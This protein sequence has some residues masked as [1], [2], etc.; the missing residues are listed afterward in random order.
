VASIAPSRRFDPIVDARV[1]ADLSER[2]RVVVLGDIGGFGIGSA[3]DFTWH[4]LAALG[5]R[6]SESW[7]LSAGYRALESE[8]PAG[9]LLYHGPILGLGHRF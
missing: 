8:R 6:P 1:R 3:S 4:V 5:L 9:D 7:M 2:F